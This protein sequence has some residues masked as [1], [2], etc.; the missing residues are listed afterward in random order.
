MVLVPAGTFTMGSP[1][2][3]PGHQRHETQHQVTLTRAFYICDHEVTQ[4]EWQSVMGWNDSRFDGADRPVEQITWW[5]CIQYCNLRSAQEGLDSV[6]VMS[7]RSYAGAHITTAT[8]TIPNWNRNGYRLPTEAEWE[9]ACRAGT[10][11]ALCNGPLTQIGRPCARDSVLELVGWYCAN[12]GDTTHEVMELPPNA[13]GLHDMHGNVWEW[14][15]DWWDGSDY[16]SG[17]VTDPTGA[18]SG[19]EHVPRGGGW[20]YLAQDCRSACRGRFSPLDRYQALGVR[21]VRSAR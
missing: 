4:S 21:V 5:D 18:S 13:L 2:E 12:A 1:T 14:C 15:W 20:K 9:Y 8:V 19:L 11:T 10:S 17:A 6:Y 16:G 3:E 7:A